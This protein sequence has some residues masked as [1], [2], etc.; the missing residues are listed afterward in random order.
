MKET[1]IAMILIEKV[2][3]NVGFAKLHSVTDKN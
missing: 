1:N 3:L 2:K